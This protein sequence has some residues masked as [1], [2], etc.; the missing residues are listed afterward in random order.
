LDILSIFVGECGPRKEL[1]LVAAEARAPRP[2]RDTNDEAPLKRFADGQVAT[3]ARI[4]TDGLASYDADSLGDRPYERGPADEGRAARG[5]RPAGLPLDHLPTQALASGHACV[6][7][8]PKHLPAYLDEFTFRH[9]RRRTN[10]VGRIAARG[11]ERFVARPP[12]TMRSL[13]DDKR[14]ARWFRSAQAG[15]S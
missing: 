4:V 2:R 8:R 15:L 6:R 5:R 10:G 11:I 3:D 9:D 12:L 7:D 13:I 14:R 1:V